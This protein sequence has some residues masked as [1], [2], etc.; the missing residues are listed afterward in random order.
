MLVGEGPER[1]PEDP[2]QAEAQTTAVMI[3]YGL[4]LRISKTDFAH[5]GDEYKGC[6]FRVQ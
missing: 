5:Q 2:P 1:E 6:V 3:L 4:E